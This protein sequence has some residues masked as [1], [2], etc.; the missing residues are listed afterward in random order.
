MGVVSAVGVVN[1]VGCGQCSGV[2]LVQWVVGWTPTIAS[3]PDVN[4]GHL[5]QPCAIH[6]CHGD[7]VLR[8][9]VQTRTLR[10]ELGHSK[11]IGARTTHL[12]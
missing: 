5:P 11:R 4:S 1:E 7:G 2:W 3:S 12:Q 9:R 8:L 10:M 6:C